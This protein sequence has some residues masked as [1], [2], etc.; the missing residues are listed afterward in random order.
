MKE[1]RRDPITNDIVVLAKNRSKR[2]MDKVNNQNDK[3]VIEEYRKDCPFCRG[4]EKH[5]EKCT[6]EIKGEDGWIVRSVYN[7]FPI[8]DSLSEE[9]FGHHEVMI[10]TNRHNGNFYNMSEEEFFYLLKMYKDRYVFMAK[11]EQV[12]YISIFKNFLR[13]AG[14]SLI[15]PHSQIISLSIVPPEVENE[16][17]I[18]KR[19]YEKNNKSLYEHIIES[20]L[21]YQERVIHDH[22]D[23]LL[24]VPEI[25]KYGGEI[26][27]FFKTKKR[28]EELKEAELKELGRI[29]ERLFKKMYE[30]HGYNPFNICIHT[31][32]INTD[33]K[34]EEHFRTHIHIIPRKY[35]FGGFELSTDLYVSSINANELAKKLRFD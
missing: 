20:E 32:P 6:F 3:E 10:D 12:K 5:T 28:F 8:V 26:R 23:Y 30:V 16:I 2:P 7:K 33:E 35:S 4:N 21:K 17:N 18:S 9:I 11:N 31:H 29:L 19:Y 34:H 13:R 1:L 22:K 14:A 15:H 25:A 27:L 24:V